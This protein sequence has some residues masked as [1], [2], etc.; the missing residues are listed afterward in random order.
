MGKELTLEEQR[1]QGIVLDGVL[2]DLEN[3]EKLVDLLLTEPNKVKR[4]KR[5]RS[6]K[7]D[8]SL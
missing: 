4:T 6:K 3:S 5:N 1:E 8:T 2:K 7:P